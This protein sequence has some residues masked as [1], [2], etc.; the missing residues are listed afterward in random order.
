VNDY[1]QTTNTQI[2]ALGDCIATRERC[3]K[4]TGTKILKYK[5][6]YVHMCE[7][8]SSLLVKNAFL[9]KQ[10]NW[11]EVPIPRT[12]FTLPQIAVVGKYS[13]QLVDEGI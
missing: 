7:E 3:S 1:L 9:F 6:Y 2:F 10:L 4:L 11:L 8:L 5:D 12:I 13:D